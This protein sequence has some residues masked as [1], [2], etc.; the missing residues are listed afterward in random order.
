MVQEGD[1]TYQNS[2]PN[3][4]RSPTCYPHPPAYRPSALTLYL[5]LPYYIRRIQRLV[6]RVPTPRYPIASGRPPSAAVVVVLLF[7]R[8][9][10]R[11]VRSVRGA[12]PGALASVPFCAADAG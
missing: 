8:Q 9:H 2:I 12:A 7:V 11:V 5:S 4:Y 10:G 6:E 3:L 1:E